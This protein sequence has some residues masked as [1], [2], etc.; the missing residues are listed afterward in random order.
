MALAVP[1]FLR[2]RGNGARRRDEGGR[3]ATCAASGHAAQL[4]LLFAVM[5]PGDVVVAST[6][7]YGGSLT[8]FGK[9]ITKFGWECLFVDVDDD[10]AVRAALA[11]P[12]CKARACSSSYLSSIRRLFELPPRRQRRRIDTH[13]C[14]DVD[15]AAGARRRPHTTPTPPPTRRAR[16]AGEQLLWAESL[17][18]P[19]GVVSDIEAL[20]A[21]ARERP[22]GP[23]PLAIDNTMA[24]PY[25][26]RPFEH[27]ADVVVH[28]TTKASIYLSLPTSCLSVCR[29]G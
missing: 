26:C 16:P 9:T 1:L 25:L 17:A 19:G 27:G 21:A 15:T 20:A 14:V 12:R 18:N 5:Q 3:G 29:G 24:T 23:V 8:Q 7:L 11:H 6:R 10:A 4:L 13:G 22:G 28:S 2:E